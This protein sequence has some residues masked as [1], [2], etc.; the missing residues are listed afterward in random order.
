MSIGEVSVELRLG[1]L[2]LRW[3]G[4]VISFAGAVIIRLH[5]AT[6]FGLGV[7]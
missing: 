2:K 6:C 5:S 3:S 1:V 4:D 7:A